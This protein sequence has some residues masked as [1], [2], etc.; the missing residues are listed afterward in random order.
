MVRATQGDAP[1]R[2]DIVAAGH[3]LTADEPPENGGQGVGPSPFDLVLAGLSACTLITLRMYAERK[4]WAGFDISTQ[5]RHR[6][7]GGAHLIDRKVEVRGPPDA[8]AVERLR[9]IVER[10]P[11]TL[12]LKAGFTISTVL[13][14]AAAHQPGAAP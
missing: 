12:A 13:G 6:M 11:V 2:V 10:T 3:S 14:E 7:E 8:A 5:L 1:Y 9:D 4:G